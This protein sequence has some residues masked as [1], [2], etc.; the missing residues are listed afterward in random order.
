MVRD[1][2]MQNAGVRD[3]VNKTQIYIY[4]YIYMYI[5]IHVYTNKHIQNT[6]T[7]IPTQMILSTSST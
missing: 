1:F 3:K 7:A 2:I 5:Y 4:I 6:R